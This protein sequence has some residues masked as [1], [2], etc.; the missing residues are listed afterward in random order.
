MTSANRILV[1][2]NGSNLL[3]ALERQLPIATT[4]LNW[5]ELHG[6]DL[7]LYNAM[8]LS[9]GSTFVVEG[10]ESLLADEMEIV[11]TFE[12]PIL[13][14]CYG[15][16]VIVKAFGGQLEQMPEDHKGMID[17]EVVQSDAIFGNHQR[18]S[19]FEHHQWRAR[20]LP[21]DF[22]VLATSTHGPEAIRHRN[23][24]VYG[25]QFHPEKV[26]D[27]GIGQSLLSNFLSLTTG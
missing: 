10:H 27:E 25:S 12:R 14:I 3:H 2:N 26:S 4:V 17:I 1:V 16:E 6:A 15:M 13:G 20:S 8:V 5:N 24:Q 9:G 18:F 11:R 23:R 7:H 22:V 21:K 19:L